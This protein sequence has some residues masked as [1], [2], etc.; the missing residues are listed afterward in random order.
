MAK[1][2]RFQRLTKLSF[3]RH[4]IAVELDWRYPQL[5]DF[6]Q[7][8]PSYRLAHFVARGE[9]APGSRP[10]PRDFEQVERTYRAFGGV[11]RTYFGEWWFRTA[12][13]RFGVSTVPKPH[14]FLRLNEL[15]D[16]PNEPAEA[17]RAALDRYTAVERPAEGMPASLIV[18][19]PVSRDRRRVMREIEALIEREFGPERS[20]DPETFM[21]LI[22]NKM[23]EQTLINAMRVLQAQSAV[24]RAPLYMVGNYA[25]IAPHYWT[26]PKIKRRESPEVLEKR[27]MMEIVTSRQLRRA[28]LLAENAARGRFPCLDPLP[29]DPARPQFNYA[30][31][32]R[33]FRNYVEWGRKR[34][35]EIK[36]ERAKSRKKPEDAAQATVSE[37]RS[38][39]AG[40]SPL[41]HD[42]ASKGVH[43]TWRRNAVQVWNRRSRDVAERRSNRTIVGRWEPLW[44][45]CRADGNLLPNNASGTEAIALRWTGVAMLEA[46]KGFRRLKAH[47]QLPILK[48]ALAAHAARHNVRAPLERED[49][50]A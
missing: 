36:A 28:Y 48:A 50:A 5:F 39:R 19:I 16:A 11:Y 27:M 17:I 25:K 33:Q 38:S 22:D 30:V 15:E 23:R 40:P 14:K 43:G 37:M 12:Q 21:R 34:V 1:P 46:A 20:D 31:L 6:L 29:E 42:A 3:E 47:R 2:D 9:I 24:P 4:D 18:A 35:A 45:R 13:F 44:S 41:R 32:G 8:S 49:A 26:D 7:I 10:L